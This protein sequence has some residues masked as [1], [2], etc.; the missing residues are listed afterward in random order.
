MFSVFEYEKIPVAFETSFPKVGAKNF[1]TV[2][3]FLQW[4]LTWDPGW[5][6]SL[7]WELCKC[8]VLERKRL[9]WKKHRNVTYVIYGA[10]YGF[11]GFPSREGRAGIH[12]ILGR[13]KT[14]G[15]LRLSVL[16]SLSP[17]VTFPLRVSSPLSACLFSAPIPPPFSL[18]L[19]P[20]HP[21]CRPSAFPSCSLKYFTEPCVSIAQSMNVWGLCQ[22]R[23]CYFFPP[24]SFVH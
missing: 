17:S 6:K 1:C 24:F 2:L 7:H 15:W 12:I 13:K 19:P 3:Y 10:Y 8:S 22:C 21:L 14:L 9:E 5:W 23:H 20:F 16:P 4:R 11:S 18:A